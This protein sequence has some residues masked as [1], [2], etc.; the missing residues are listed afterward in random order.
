VIPRLA[1]KGQ[2]A[3]DGD[4]PS[5]L[6]FVREWSRR[7]GIGRDKGWS[8]TGE[9]KGKPSQII[10]SSCQLKMSEER[11]VPLSKLYTSKDGPAR[12]IYSGRKEGMQSGWK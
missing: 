11:A 5:N 2:F 10:S 12:W 4:G 7:I 9:C 6:G 8:I 1:G 3:K